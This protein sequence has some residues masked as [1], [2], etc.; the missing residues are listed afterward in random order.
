MAR[1]LL[2]WAFLARAAAVADEVKSLPGVATLKNKHY[3]GYAVVNETTDRQLF[4]WFVEAES[5]NQPG[6]TPNII[7]MNGGP[8]AS[9]I[10]GLMVENIGPLTLQQS[11][12]L[13]ENPH[14][15]SGKNNVMIIDN[16][17]GSGFS[18][19]GKE[20]Y[21]KSE[22]EMREDFYTALKFIFTQ[23]P[24]YARNPLWVTGESYGGKYVPNVAYEIHIRGEFPLKGII[25]G[26]GVY[27]GLIQNP[28]VPEFAYNQ[29]LIDEHQLLESKLIIAELRGDVSRQLQTSG[30]VTRTEFNAAVAALQSTDYSLGGALDSAWLCLCGAL[31]MF[32]HAGFAMLE[33][34][35]CRVK[36]ASNVL[37]K[38]LVNVC[39]GTLG[40]W[41]FGWAFAYGS[42]GTPANGFIGTDGFFGIGF[43]T[44]DATTGVISPLAS[45][46]ADGCQS[47]MLSW[48]F[49]W[50]FCTAGA[51]IVS[52]GV[53][54]RVKSPTYA[55][56]AFFMA[57]F[58]YPII[59]AWSWGGGFLATITS[60][61]YMDF[62][63]SGVVHLTGGVSAL[64]GTVVL[65][66]RK[67]RFENPEEFECHNLPLVVLGTFALWFGWYG[68]NPGS[69][70]GMHD[71]ATGALA[72]QVAMNTTLAAATG[73]ITVFLLRYVITKK[74]DVGGLCNGI[75]AGLVSITAGCGNV[76]CGSAFAIGLVGA[77]VY[78]GSSML[79]QK[80]KIDDPVDA[81]PVHGFCGIWGVLAAGFLD[82]GKGIDQY[83]GW[84]GWGCVTEGTACKTGLGG[85]AIGAQFALIGMVILW[86]GALS[87]IAF[88]VL[89]LTGLLRI[90]EEVEEV[91]IDCKSHS[92]AKAYSLSAE[93]KSMNSVVCVQPGSKNAWGE[94][95]A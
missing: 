29:G 3:A 15:W 32:M 83:H 43:Y 8:G 92:P 9:S 93:A 85:D 66:P 86:S 57:S 74:Y 17:V 64:A 78:Q 95:T 16:P 48:F 6:V 81:S 69:T 11:G 52:G 63:G 79:L 87:T 91:G 60:V 89:K 2:L 47:T 10:M 35:S 23:H 53:A 56:Y 94:A 7:W 54:E 19:T 18:F 65:G 14:A 70:L 25:I 34:G 90:S 27:S 46:D 33:T 22:K 1:A 40:W 24:E 51:T 39:V 50:A 4:Y 37:M 68:F 75:L 55:V 82:W 80:L 31:V 38:N 49:Q 84:S 72:A 26:N 12:E 5:G 62:A 45:C 76:E 88:L 30:W 77:F 59:V 21:V 61:G 36:N 13:A 42:Q 58:I 73:G 41:V 71:G 67:G 20:S 44:V 28:T